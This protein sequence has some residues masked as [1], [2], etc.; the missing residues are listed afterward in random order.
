MLKYLNK[1]VIFILLITINGCNLSDVLT[2]PTNLPK[3]IT[4]TWEGQMEI[5]GF[6]NS[7]QIHNIKISINLIDKPYYI[8]MKIAGE[9]IKVNIQK[10][11]VLK[12]DN[13]IQYYIKNS[14]DSAFIIF[15]D[16]TH[17][18]LKGNGT[19]DLTKIVSTY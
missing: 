13:A 6:M 16:Q 9:E 3:S 7:K 2:S 17:I 18:Q 19:I 4:G 11:K 12:Q 8:N 5:D 10:I 15:I 14:K 1:I